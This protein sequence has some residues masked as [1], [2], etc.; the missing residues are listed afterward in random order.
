MVNIMCSTSCNVI[1]NDQKNQ[2]EKVV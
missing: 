1:Y 2:T